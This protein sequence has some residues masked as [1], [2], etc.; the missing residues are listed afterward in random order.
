MP[1]RAHGA[2]AARPVRNPADRRDIVGH[3][4]EADDAAVDAALAVAAGEGALWQATPPEQR[5]ACL[6]RAADLLEATRRRR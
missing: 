5:A 4:V 3:V 2:G 6:L 1:R